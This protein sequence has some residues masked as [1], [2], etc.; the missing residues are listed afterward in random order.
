MGEGQPV[1]YRG[2]SRPE[3]ELTF[4]EAK[5]LV[6]PDRPIPEQ[7]G[8]ARSR[9]YWNSYNEAERA[10]S[11]GKYER[12][13]A[14]LSKLWAAGGMHATGETL[15]L[16][17]LR[18][19]RDELTRRGDG[20]AALTLSEQMLSDSRLP[21]TATDDRAHNKIAQT[22]GLPTREIRAGGTAKRA[23]THTEV[24]LSTSQPWA[25]ADHAWKATPDKGKSP[26]GERLIT[27]SGT[28][29]VGRRWSDEH[30]QWRGELRFHDAHGNPAPVA[31]IDHAP[32]RLGWHPNDSV[33]ATLNADDLTLN[34]YEFSGA[35]RRKLQLPKSGGERDHYH[36]RAVA[37][38][39][40]GDLFTTAERV[41][42]VAPSGT[43]QWSARTPPNAGWERRV[44]GGGGDRNPEQQRAAEILGLDEVTDRDGIVAAYRAKARAHHPDLH[45]D[46]PNATARMQE[47]NSAYELLTG[48][49]ASEILNEVVETYKT[50]SRHT[51]EL[52]GGESFEFEI[53]MVGGGDDWIYAAALDPADGSVFLGCYSGRVFVLDRNANVLSLLD[54]HTTMRE[55]M[56][57]QEALLLRTDTRIFSVVDRSLAGEVDVWQKDSIAYHGSGFIIQQGK[58][59]ALY[60]HRCGLEGTLEASE[61]PRGF[62]RASDALVIEFNRDLVTVGGI[63]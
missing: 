59:L 17:S 33:F 35:R 6:L 11:S 43:E 60:N 36:V 14:L 8:S 5:A 12:A 57:L 44:R 32:Y 56:P 52:A 25:V 4:D 45:P 42:V 41:S 27:A 21:T 18:K 2:D 9:E 50:M 48:E 53:S 10:Y 62:W 55:I 54:V 23:G 47:I 28:V 37:T 63:F 3:I 51:V 34:V 31:D 19:Y 26:W 15:Y 20:T 49:S 7:D 58:T 38:S 40:F 1:K 16:R 30:S 22:L 39:S 24:T 13:V 61:T 46:D 29:E